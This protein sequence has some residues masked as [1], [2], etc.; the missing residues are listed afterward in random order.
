MNGETKKKEYSSDRNTAS[1]YTP[2]N[3][4]IRVLVIQEQ[5]RVASL[6]TVLDSHF[7][8]SDGLRGVTTSI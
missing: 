1:S 7:I 2:Q 4:T 8:Q 3:A 5:F 6:T